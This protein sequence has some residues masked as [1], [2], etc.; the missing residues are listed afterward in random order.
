M[1]EPRGFFISRRARRFSQS[2]GRGSGKRAPGRKR[3]CLIIPMAAFGLH[4]L[5]EGLFI[6]ETATSVPL[7]TLWT[8]WVVAVQRIFDSDRV[9]HYGLGRKAG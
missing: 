6:L 5:T 4:F 3:Y 7:T 1:T 8:G 2:P 9:A